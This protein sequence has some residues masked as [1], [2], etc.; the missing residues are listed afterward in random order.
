LSGAGSGLTAELVDTGGDPVIGRE[1]IRVTFPDGRVEELHL[2]DYDRLYALP[3]VYETI[4]HDRL[5][6]RSP[7]EIAAIVGGAV[8]RL[9]WSRGAIRVIDVAAGNGVSGEALAAEGLRPVIGSDIVPAAGEAVRRDRPDLYEQ[10]LVLDLLDLAPEDAARLAEFEANVLCA[11]AVVGD[12]PKHL[13]PAALAVAARALTPDALIANIHTPGEAAPVT[14]EFWVDQL[15][16]GTQAE[17]L[18][19]RLYLHRRTVTGGRYELEGV[20]WRVRRPA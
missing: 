20:V 19:R 16:A 6:C 7:A 18:E 9:G 14:P 10:Y 5:G 3:G 12:G 4:V 1:L 8:D 15:G 2:H 11:V 17:E 13:P